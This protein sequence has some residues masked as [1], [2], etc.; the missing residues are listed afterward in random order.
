MASLLPAIAYAETQIV[1][2]GYQ[3]PLSGA[4]SFLGN[5]QLDAVNYA[6]K[7]FNEY[8]LGK[9]EVKVLT[10][11]DQGDPSI[12]ANLSPNFAKNTKIV[13]VVGPAY[14]GASITSLPNY[15]IAGLTVISPS[16]TR[17]SLT[18]PNSTSNFGGPVFYRVAGNSKIET[19][20]IIES[21]VNSRDKN[22]FIATDE[23][24]FA[25]EQGKEVAQSLKQFG[26]TVLGSGE[27]KS[28]TV[29]FSVLLSK[30]DRI[31]TEN[32]LL[33]GYNKDYAALM[34]QLSVIY[35][36]DVTMGGEPDL[37]E[38]AMLT[39]KLPF[40]SIQAISSRLNAKKLIPVVYGDY[41][42]A[43]GKA[44]GDE[45]IRTI[46]ATNVFLSCI[47]SG[48]LNRLDMRNCVKNYK[49]RNLFGDEF[50]FSIGGDLVN[51]AS[52]PYLA[53][54]A[55]NWKNEPIITSRP[56]STNVL[57]YFS[58]AINEAANPII[59]KPQIYLTGRAQTQIDF[60]LAQSNAISCAP[61][62]D[63]GIITRNPIL[64]GNYS[65]TG[66]QPSNKVNIKI[67]CKVGNFSQFFTEIFE[68]L[69]P[70]PILPPL[71]GSTADITSILVVFMKFNSDYKY[72]FVSSAGEVY[73]YVDSAGSLNEDNETILK[74][75]NLQP[76]S[77]VTLQLK[78][79]DQFGQ[80]SPT[81]MW[82]FSTPLPPLPRKPKLILIS[83]K[84]NQIIYKMVMDE[85]VKAK[86]TSTNCT[87]TYS[88]GIL[89]IR[90]QSS[91]IVCKITFYQTDRYGRTVSSS[92][93][94]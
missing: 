11:D 3:G 82:E 36:K 9:I 92:V 49:G 75:D 25:V 10:L 26:I 31:L 87:A 6:V 30:I 21:I 94:Q 83:K 90:K 39:G 35:S 69:P 14:S 54:D 53:I 65:I 61:S 63:I 74:I 91:R 4:E 73:E 13:G 64:M 70:N 57:N 46:D 32:V 43:T 58:W 77:K 18:D 88:S 29:D 50:S 28:G 78:A 68:S 48:N 34:K 27:F 56:N 15:K 23:A 7:K 41:L 66:L 72:E 5:E 71:I 20:K 81:Q 67:E 16:A 12:A 51:S 52:Y 93:T 40:R 55:T 80:L 85:G 79:I 62:S 2:I 42:L 22:I 86:V 8:N 19:K 76:G 84:T 24:S 45:T 33:I 38:M 44:P 89:A 17:E 47:T 60:S 1:Y 37:N 59:Q